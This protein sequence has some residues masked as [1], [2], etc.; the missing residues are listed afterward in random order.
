MTNQSGRRSLSLGQRDP[1]VTHRG[2][3]NEPT[4][5]LQRDAN[6]NWSLRKLPAMGNTSATTV[7]ELRDVVNQLLQLLRDNEEMEA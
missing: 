3:V 1:R 5:R 4:G 7:E 2:P 6:G